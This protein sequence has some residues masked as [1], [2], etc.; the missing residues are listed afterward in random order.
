MTAIGPIETK[1]NSIITLLSNGQIQA[2]LDSALTL[3]KDYPKNSMLLNITGACYAGLDQLNDA[4]DYYER[5]ISIKPDYAKA[6]YNLAGA[7][8]ELGRLDESVKNYQKSLLIEPN[9]AE[10]HN[11]L[12]NVYIE[13]G[14]LEDAVKSFEQAIA[15]KPDY[16]EAYYSLGISLQDLGRLEEAIE[17]YLEVLNIKPEFAEMHN[18]LGVAFKGLGRI[19]E[20]ISNYQKAIEINPNYADAFNNLGNLY[21]DLS[22]LDQ[23]VVSYE[24]A[25]AINPNYADPQ[26]NLGIAQ[27]ELNQLDM[28]IKSFQKALTLNPDFPEAYNNLGNAHRELSEFDQS[29]KSYKKA[30]ELNPSYAEALNNL[31]NVYRDLNQLDRAIN[32]YERAISLKPEFV[33]PKNNLGITHIDLGQLDDAIKSF[34]SALIIDPEYPEAYNNLA[35][36]FSKLGQ[37]EDAEKYNKNALSLRPDFADAHAIR[38]NIMN[39]L[40]RLDEAL[41]S[42]Q[43]A[44][45]INPNLNFIL[46]DVLHTRMHLCLWDDLS[47]RFKELEDKIKNNQKVVSPFA[48]MG[49]IDNPEVQRIN[50]EI[51]SKFAFPKSHILKEIDSYQHHERIRIGYFSADFNEHPVSYLTAE[52]YELHNRNNF[53]IY[54]FSYGPDTKD[55]MN[56]RIKAGVDH[57]HDVYSMSDK[58]VV[59]LA[60]SLE[61]DIAVDLGGF[62]QNSRTGIFAMQAAPIQVNYLGFS[63]TLGTSY[64]DYIIADLMLIPEKN[65]N[66]YSEKLVYLPNSYMVSDTSKDIIKKAYTKK[67]VGLPDDVF[68][69]CCFNNYYKIT[70]TVFNSWMRILSQ[71]DKSILWLPEGNSIAIK[72]LK[73]EAVKNGVDGDRLIFAP[74][75]PLVE[76]HLNRIQLADLFLDTL[77]YNAHTTSNDAIRMGLPVLTCVGESYAGRVAASLLN[78]VDLQ[79]LITTNHDQYEA[80]AIELA[81]NPKRLQ[82]IKAMLEINISS[83]AL[84]NTSLY[85]SHLENAYSKIYE[86]SKGGL[87]P[88]HIYVQN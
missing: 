43:R 55:E 24:K 10:A 82:D 81:M 33:D 47:S 38:A 64:M 59:M 5:A 41:K 27:L 52:L 75:L 84:F 46:G 70:P 42:Y 4:V 61:I 68:I 37:Y 35:I 7:L 29:V 6:F 76:D 16:V 11:N 12:G 26:N 71:V 21:R 15:N 63:G 39:E 34:E 28:A 31:G 51:Y 9:H 36:V 22:Q 77:P 57:F 30:L 83:T 8:Q 54:A 40:R 17:N 67:D 48:L 74:R 72:N 18:N 50:S 60:R 25:V 19:E 13:L 58:D 86:R 23:A 65:K 49:M 62:T 2:A 87:L 88:D 53:E 85:T 56:L 80:L 32:S 45:E 3:M 1:T 20:S 14:N 44:S 69:F 73:K 78:A 79:E 66:H